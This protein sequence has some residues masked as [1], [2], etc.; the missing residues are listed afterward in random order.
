MNMESESLKKRAAAETTEVDQNSRSRL[1][2][3]DPLVGMKGP[4]TR[5]KTKRMQEA[6]N[7]FIREIHDNIKLRKSNE[8]TSVTV[9]QVVSELSTTPSTLKSNA[10][11][12]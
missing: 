4:M 1:S 2:Y 6:L 10:L 8:S 3:D 9:L 7:Q 12:N 5:S 11:T